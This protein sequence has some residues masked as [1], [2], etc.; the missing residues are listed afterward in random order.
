MEKPPLDFG[1][2]SS[3]WPSDTETVNSQI[4]QTRAWLNSVHFV[5]VSREMSAC[6][7]FYAIT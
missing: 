7:R 1:P 2:R 6:K 4:L 3:E 5:S